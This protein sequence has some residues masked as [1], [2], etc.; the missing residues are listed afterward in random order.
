MKNKELLIN[1]I[2]Q[3]E[4]DGSTNI[5]TALYYQSEN[6]IFIGSAAFAEA[7]NPQDVNFD[8][9]VDLGNHDPFGKAKQTFQTACGKRLSSQVLTKDFLTK[10][11]GYT[12]E[13]LSRNSIEKGTR[14]L[15]AEP[16]AM[17]ENPEWLANY[18]KNLKIILEKRR[19]VG[20]ENIV[21]E[22]LDFLPEPFAV[23][24]YYRYG[25]RHPLLIERKK[26]QALVLDFGGGTLDVCIIETTK[27]G[28]ISQSGRNSKPLAAQSE[29]VGGFYINRL[30]AEHL[31][32]KHVIQK[33]FNAQ[34]GKMFAKGL[35]IYSDWRLNQTDLSTCKEEYQS[36]VQHFHEAAL[37]VENMKLSLCKCVTDWKL[38]ALLNTKAS[39]KI[40]T[41]P[42]A[43][44]SEYFSVTFSAGDLRD[45][46]VNEVW[47]SRIKPVL[48]KTIERGLAEL[49]GAPITVV[50]LSGGSANIGWLREL[51][52]R[53]FADQLANAE[54]LQLPD[55]Q[56]VVAKGL[57]VECA[58]RFYSED[59]DFS[60]VTYNRLCLV[61]EPNGKGPQLC[62]FTPMV[63]D[64]PRSGMDGVLLPSASLVKSSIGKPIRW[65]V[66]HLTAKPKRLDYFFL[67]SS[68]DP[69]D[70]ESLQNI[71]ERT[72]FAP[73]DCAYDAEMKLELLVS[74]DGTA[75]PKF[76]FKT[77]QEKD[78]VATD[79]KPFYLD[80]TYGQ[81]AAVSSAY[82]GLDFGTSNTSVSFIN[83]ETIKVQERRASE[84]SWTELSDLTQILPYPIA[85]PLALFLQQTETT[86]I[87][88]A[89]REFIE[90]T[91]AL[92][93]Y[94]AFLEG[95]LQQRSVETHLFKCFT[96]RSAGPLWRLLQESL[97]VLPPDAPFSSGFK[98]LLKPDFLKVIQGAVN[99]VAA[100]KHDKITVPD[101]D[102]LRPI[103]VLANIC[104]KV[105][106]GSV[107]GSF[108]QVKKIAFSKQF[109]ATFREAHGSP[110]FLHTWEY[111][112][113]ECFSE[114][115]LFLIHVESRKALRLG[116]LFFWKHC[117]R[118]P[119]FETGHCYIYDIANKGDGAFSFKSVSFPCS[120]EIT[121]QSADDYKVIAEQLREMR[122][123]DLLC[124]L[125]QLET[126]IKY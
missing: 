57:A 121:C 39:A 125:V 27:D 62:L 14:V 112:G 109:Q 119:E 26:N 2:P 75:R 118:H 16:L 40:P 33:S 53:D 32:R 17:H 122:M 25:Y 115:E 28:E 123:Q 48:T 105:F 8:F 34:Y 103:K 47:E 76:I 108:E 70:A 102:I 78:V 91:L 79:G 13:W 5:P 1:Q 59:G 7:K 114:Q 49:N 80:M 60:S 120:C 72:V 66:H 96:Q 6:N 43:K 56:E 73:H 82:I 113:A 84:R 22:N 18:R 111:K 97:A 67:R 51:L 71:E 30:I 15:L 104:Q 126:F 36:F 54:V 9:K 95:C 69:Q 35:Q 42:F 98:E 107:F 10:V 11:L 110:P 23:F 41:A 93:S 29:A 50:L 92:A 124:E 81:T 44:D 89:G 77:G 55:F 3:I 94:I 38:D 63:R 37:T 45:L 90:A 58:R 99:F 64:F 68:F 88:K 74:E 116:P 117:L 21:F 19:F 31:F 106:E 85:A 86:R 65:K 46:F 52:N 100:E 24:Q 83:R 87:H 101:F 12:S 4:V 61:L 20:I